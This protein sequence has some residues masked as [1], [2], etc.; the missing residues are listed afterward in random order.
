MS[1]TPAAEEEPAFVLTKSF[2]PNK[3]AAGEP[4]KYPTHHHPPGEVVWDGR[5]QMWFYRTEEQ[6]AQCLKVEKIDEGKQDRM[7]RSNS[8]RCVFI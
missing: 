7:R 8:R 4:E 1:T 5:R 6:Q 3:K 2:K